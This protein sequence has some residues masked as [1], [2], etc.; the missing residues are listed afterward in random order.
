MLARRAAIRVHIV[1]AAFA[2]LRRDPAAACA[3]F[4]AADRRVTT[5]T[6]STRAHRSLR[7]RTRITR[8][9]ALAISC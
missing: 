5:T 1:I 6:I 4:A 9:V 2:T 7:P 8:C 3:A